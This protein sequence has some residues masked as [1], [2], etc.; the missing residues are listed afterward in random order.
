MNALELDKI[1]DK[2]E[3]KLQKTYDIILKQLYE[4]LLNSVKR[5]RNIHN[6]KYNIPPFLIGK[7]LFNHAECLCYI[8]KKLEN[9]GF[10]VNYDPPLG[11]II[12]LK[13]KDDNTCKLNNYLK[14]K[15]KK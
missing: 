12:N 2:R 9:K 6:F 8:I 4:S 3:K 5:N 11:I 10:K 15:I 1:K 14:S 13:G 7:P